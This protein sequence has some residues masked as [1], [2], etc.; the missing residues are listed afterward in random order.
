M[1]NNHLV[2]ET[3]RAAGGTREALLT[4]LK[5]NGP[6]APSDLAGQLGVTP[7]AVRQHLVILERSGLVAREQLRRR[8]GRPA[9][10]WHLAPAAER[11]FPDGHA[12]LCV[13]LTAGLSAALP[14]ADLK[15][16]LNAFVRTAVGRYDRLLPRNA[17]FAARVRALAAARDAEGFMVEL[18]KRPG[19]AFELIEHHCPVGKAAQAFP[20]L[21]AAE[22][23]ALCAALR[24]AR[25]TLQAHRLHGAECC[26]LRI[27]R[28][29]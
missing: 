29:R 23:R 1:C 20:E 10:L 3:R 22:T 11:I 13:D 24:G 7:T 6:R 17:S 18:R 27:T 25:V 4:L 21:C 28:A 9:R 16:V 8:R 2:R 26:V 5:R 15:R 12:A 19:D 14:R